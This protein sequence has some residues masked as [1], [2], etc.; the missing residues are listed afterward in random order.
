MADLGA[1][2]SRACINLRLSFPDKNC[3]LKYNM[4]MKHGKDYRAL[5][6]Q[7]WCRRA[8]THTDT[9]QRRCLELSAS[10]ALLC[11]YLR[12][13]YLDCII[14]L[15][16]HN[17]KGNGAAACTSRRPRANRPTTVVATKSH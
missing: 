11:R 17:S 2:Q 12:A 5:P 16:G 3:V 14:L 1:R 4:Y 13:I 6:C 7:I 9:Q 10:H 15:E 8:D